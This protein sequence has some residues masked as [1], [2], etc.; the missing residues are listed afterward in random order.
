MSMD[1]FHCFGNHEVFINISQGLT[2]EEVDQLFSKPWLKRTN[3]VY[4]LRCGCFWDLIVK[5]RSRVE[6][7]EETQR[8]EISMDQI[9]LS[10]SS[11]SSSDEDS[12]NLTPDKVH[13]E[14]TSDL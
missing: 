7:S 9:S 10:S 6:Q 5:R 11:S 8:L 4:Y 12:T 1:P 13:S 2:L 14:L 3:V